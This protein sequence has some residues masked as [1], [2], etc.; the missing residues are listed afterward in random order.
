MIYQYMAMYP[1]GG[2]PA[3]Y[4][5]NFTMVYR[6]YIELVNGIITYL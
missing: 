3:I 5:S 6:W 1:Q 4:K 2:A